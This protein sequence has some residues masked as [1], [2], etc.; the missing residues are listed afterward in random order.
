MSLRTARVTPP[1]H[2]LEGMADKRG[3]EGTVDRDIHEDDVRLT[4]FK[5][6]TMNKERSPEVYK[7]R[8]G[9]GIDGTE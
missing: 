8:S 6:Q 4:I 5:L 1:R 2:P 3:R 9:S 7:Y